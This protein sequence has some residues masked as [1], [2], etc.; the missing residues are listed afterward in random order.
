MRVIIVGGGEVGSY[1]SESLSNENH[2]IIMIEESEEKARLIDEAQNIT[3]IQGNGN[4]CK[5]LVDAHVNQ[6]D[7][8][9]AMTSDDRTNLLSSSLAKALGANHTITRIHDQTFS[10]NSIV[11]YQHHF[12]IDY[13]FNP[14]ALCAVE[15][16]KSMRNP[17]RVFIE[18][19]ARGEIEVQQVLVAKR[20][21]AAGKS[22]I[23]LKLDSRVKIGYITR[24]EQVFVG[25]ADTVI[26]AGDLITLF[27]ETKILYELK[28]IFDPSIQ[29]EIV[30]VA[31]F[32]GTEIAIALI[33]LL[34]NPRFNIRVLEKDESVCQSLAEQFPQIDVV[35]GDATSLRFLEEERLGE[36]DYFIACTKKDEEN[37]MTSLQA[38]KLGVKHVQ[39]VINKSDYEHLLNSL[40]SVMG[41]DLIV[42]PRVATANEVERVLSREDYIELGTL[43]NEIGKVLEI[44]VS[45]ESEN[46]GKELKDLNLPKGVIVVALDHKFHVKVPGADDKILAGDRM[47]LIS[48]EEEIE[49]VLELLL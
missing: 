4:S 18:N 24:G 41:V 44:R 15:L 12:G 40:K 33:R 29:G 35:H 8:F 13:M 20:S 27:G 6:C 49:K 48:K 46:T 36:C 14:E 37:I 47:V 38:S 5:T 39:V 32:G 7:Y 9:L 42:S 45:F 17:Y 10:D 26:H 25:E 22:I 11:N 34:S 16:A 1:L 2:D 28:P 21:K 19:F 31:L 23:D 30:N 43:P 3:V